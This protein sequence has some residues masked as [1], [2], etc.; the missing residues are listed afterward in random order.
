MM[1]VVSVVEEAIMGQ[2]SMDICGELMK[3]SGSCG[4]RRLEADA[5]RMAGQRF[6]GFVTTAGFMR[7]GEDVLGSLVGDDRLVARNEEAVWEAV[8]GWMKGAAARGEVGW[9]GIVGKVRFPLMGEEYLRNRV[10]GMVGWEDEEWM[11]GVVAEAL[12]AKAARLEG[13]VIEFK[14]LGKKC[15]GWGWT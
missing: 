12:R 13:A 8:V 11:A 3:W 7:I 2:L 4:L 10:V 5:L 1:E 14:V 9:C 15:I 6:E